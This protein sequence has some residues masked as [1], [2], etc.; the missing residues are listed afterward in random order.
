MV[1]GQDVG[2][3][4]DNL[5]VLSKLRAAAVVKL[6]GYSPADK[7]YFDEYGFG[8]RFVAHFGDSGVSERLSYIIDDN[9]HLNLS[10]MTALLLFHQGLSYL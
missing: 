1:H 7:S 5:Q 6:Y 10:L 8:Q 2:L 9:Y 3:L 4:L